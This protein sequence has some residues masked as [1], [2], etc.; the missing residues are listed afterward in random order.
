[1]WLIAAFVAAQKIQT[2]TKVKSRTSV[3]RKNYANLQKA[4]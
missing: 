3:I 4:S 2:D 1:M